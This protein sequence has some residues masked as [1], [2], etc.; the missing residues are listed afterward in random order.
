MHTAQMRSIL[1]EFKKAERFLSIK[2]NG[3]RRNYFITISIPQ[4][5]KMKRHF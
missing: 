2:I 5:T 3:N 4:I 1:Y